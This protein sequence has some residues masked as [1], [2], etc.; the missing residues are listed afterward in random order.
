MIDKASIFFSLKR[1]D[2]KAFSHENTNKVNS[3]FI[4]Q[5]ALIK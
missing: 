3:K 4:A 5:L 2:M 1:T